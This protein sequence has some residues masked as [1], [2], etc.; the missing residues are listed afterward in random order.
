MGMLHLRVVSPADR[1]EAVLAALAGLDQVQHVTYMPEVVLD[2]RGDLVTALVHHDVTDD[3]VVA[4]QRIGPWGDGMISFTDIDLSLADPRSVDRDGDEDWDVEA[5]VVVI[6]QIKQRAHHDAQGSW[7]YLMTMVAAGVIAAVGVLTDQPV[8]IVG[9]MA[10][11]PDLSR[12]TS[13]NVGV[14]TGDVSLAARAIR[15]LALGML[16]ASVASAV[17]ASGSR[18]GELVPPSFSLETLQRV[19]FV[20]RPDVFSV[21]VAV[22][23]GIAGMLAFENAKSGGAVG[24]AISVTTIP[25]AAAIGVAVALTT[26]SEALAAAA[27]LGVNVACLVVAGSLTLAVQRAVRRRRLSL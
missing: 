15:T 5:D 20:T 27:Q 3:L 18:V 1:T 2:P 14:V 23:A 6:E 25:A 4:L 16:V 7:N 26:T 22:A 8:L 11:S 13:A 9:A 24:V 19:T 17:V 21:I 12:I 10:V